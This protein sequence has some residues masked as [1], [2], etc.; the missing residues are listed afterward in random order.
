MYTLNGVQ[1]MF[2]AYAPVKLFDPIPPGFPGVRGKMF[3]IKGWGIVKKCN[4]S[5]IFGQSKVEIK[6]QKNDVPWSQQFDWCISIID[7][8]FKYLKNLGCP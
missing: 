8:S 3:A 6:R 4:Y 7:I 5:D 1:M 2:L